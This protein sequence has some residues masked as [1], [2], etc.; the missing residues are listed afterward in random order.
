[1]LRKTRLAVVL[2]LVAVSCVFLTP[3]ASAAG[4]SRPEAP[5]LY[6][7]GETLMFFFE[8]DMSGCSWA[9]LYTGIEIEANWSWDGVV[10]NGGGMAMAACGATSAGYFQRH[11][12]SCALDFE[13]QSDDIALMDRYEG[14]VRYPW[15][16]S[17]KT[18]GFAFECSTIPTP[19]CSEV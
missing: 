11:G 4:C 9:R 12:A 19:S 14:S 7:D 10:Q 8:V 18:M 17:R 2:S 3:S 5:K 15:K 13:M 1:M 6:Y 16:Q